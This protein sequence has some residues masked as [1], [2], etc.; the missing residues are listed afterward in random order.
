M[1]RRELLKYSLHGV[2][3]TIIMITWWLHW[4]DYNITIVIIF[5]NTKNLNLHV[6]K[7]R[8]RSNR[9]EVN[10]YLIWR[11]NSPGWQGTKNKAWAKW[12]PKF[13]VNINIFNLFYPKYWISPGNSSKRS[14]WD[15]EWPAL[16]WFQIQEERGKICAGLW[17]SPLC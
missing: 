12:F 6:H 16:P 14:E 11:K 4:D 1:I 7:L 5:R 15:W 17:E 8:T 3:I 9:E 2:T 10:N 13:T